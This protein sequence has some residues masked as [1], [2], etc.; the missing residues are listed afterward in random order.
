MKIISKINDCRT[1]ITYYTEAHRIELK[2]RH[3]KIRATQ[4]RNSSSLFF[5]DYQLSH[6]VGFIQN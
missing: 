5:T 2:T 4:T 1:D 3:N 6:N